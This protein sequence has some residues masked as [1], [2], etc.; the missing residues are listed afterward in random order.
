MIEIQVHHHIHFDDDLIDRLERVE[1][2]LGQIRQQGQA[3]LAAVTALASTD[4]RLK[5]F[6]ETLE[7][8]TAALQ[9]AID[10]NTQAAPSGDGGASNNPNKP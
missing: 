5:E 3:I 4:P 6:H 9:T 1:V 10:K 7:A 8:S 2:T